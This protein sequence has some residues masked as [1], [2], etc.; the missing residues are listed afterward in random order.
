MEI[1]ATTR[2]KVAKKKPTGTTKKSTAN[3]TKKTSKGIAT[4]QSVA[5]KLIPNQLASEEQRNALKSSSKEEQLNLVM[6]LMKQSMGEEP[7]LAQHAVPHKKSTAQ[8]RGTAAADLAE[9]VRTLGSKT[10][11][12]EFGVLGDIEKVV[13]PAG[14][15]G[16]LFGATGGMKR[17]SSASSLASFGATSSVHSGGSSTLKTSAAV[18]KLKTASATAR[19]GVLLVIRAL[20]E[21]IGRPHVDAF[22]TPF[23]APVIEEAGSSVGS[24][25]EAAEDTAK[26][27]ITMAH[28]LA[29]PTLICPVIFA[30]LQSPEWRV[31]HCALQRLTQMASL[32]QYK[33]QVCRMLPKIIPVV[34]SEVF[35]TKP[36]VAKAAGECLLATCKTNQNPDVA[37][38]IPAVVKS[39]IKPSETTKA[40]DELMAT[41]FVSA[42]D[43]STLSILC[44]VL[45]RGLKEKLAIHK[46]ACSIVIENMSRLVDSPQAVA[47]F[48]PLLVPELKKVSENVQFEEIRDAALAALKTLTKALGHASVEAAYA[49]M[50]AE[51]T[52]R[53]EEE[54]RRIAEE[55]AEELKREEEIKKKEEEERKQWKEAME[56]QRLLDKLA[57]EEEEQKKAEEKKQREL[58]SQSVKSKTGK[59]KGC[60]LKK[61]RKECLF[62]S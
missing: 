60:G 13:L 38:A 49:S 21:N 16:Q 1:N 10:V 39:I 19:E 3:G 32:P 54:E 51:E 12:K 53:V 20:C 27:M 28:P 57:L 14:G 47:P 62:R 25:R 56:A 30:A 2:V 15:L 5:P 59:C 41:T 45:S 7:F 46:R 52:A 26:A 31:K 8:S 4:K 34:S 29:V 6:G 22:V 37:P 58:S 23:L 35:D 11:L 55:R 24:V 42:V 44:P 50:M 17:I 33:L 61:C 18:D 48:G 36:Q 9:A 43:A 40:I